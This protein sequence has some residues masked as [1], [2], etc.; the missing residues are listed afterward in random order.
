MRAQF[1][2]L[3]RASGALAV[4]AAAVLAA[5]GGGGSGDG[6]N[7]GTTGTLAVRLTDAQSCSYEHFFVTVL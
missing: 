6:D 7:D 5:C 3:R 1:S 4:A 2:I